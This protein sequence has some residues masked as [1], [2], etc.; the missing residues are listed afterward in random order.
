VSRNTL[1]VIGLIVGAA[2]GWF[3]AP[4][5]AVDINVGGVNIQVEGD[6]SGGSIS[7]TGNGDSMEVSVGKRSPSVFAEP[8]WRALIFAVIGG[9]VGLLISTF[10]GR[11][12]AA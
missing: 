9:V 10:T 1:L 5:P 7:A 4:R 12:K 2:V 6:K 3:T 11:R 8:G